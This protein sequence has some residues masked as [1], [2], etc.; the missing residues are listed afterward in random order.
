MQGVQSPGG[1]GR[2]GI[3]AA[4]PTGRGWGTDTG[5]GAQVAAVTMQ[6]QQDSTGAPDEWQVSHLEQRAKGGHWSVVTRGVGARSALERSF[7]RQ[8][9]Q[10]YLRPLF[11]PEACSSLG[12]ARSEPAAR[13][14][15]R[16]SCVA[17]WRPQHLG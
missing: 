11:T 8:S 1:G 15:S 9:L 7:E 14:S 4:S 6:G 17:R 5:L 2:A 12:W 3:I 13:S 10:G 16:M